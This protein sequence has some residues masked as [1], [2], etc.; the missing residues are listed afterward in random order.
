MNHSK[1]DAAVCKTAIDEYN[2]D[3]VMR[4]VIVDEVEKK[5]KAVD[6]NGNH[7]KMQPQGKIL[8]I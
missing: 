2:K 8:H 3:A 6:L 7:T 5:R 1:G 4:S